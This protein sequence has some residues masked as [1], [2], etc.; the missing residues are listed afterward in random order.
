MCTY[1][2]NGKVAK[3]VTPATI[4]LLLPYK[5][6]VKFITTDK[7]LEFAEHK[8]IAQKLDTTVYFTQ[9]FGAWQKGQIENMNKLLRQHILK[10]IL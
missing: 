1:L 2:P 4:N 3:D 10:I 9:P 8:K 7:S 5:K 6:Y